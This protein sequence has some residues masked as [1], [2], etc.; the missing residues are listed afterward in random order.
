MKAPLPPLRVA[1]VGARRVRM[2]L[3]PFVAREMVRAGASLSSVVGTSTNSVAEACRD[4][5]AEFGGSVRGYTDI[6]AMLSHE[7][8]DVLA[9]LS[10]S[11]THGFYLRKALAA[12]LDVLCEKPL[13]WNEPNLCHS[14]ETLLADFQARERVLWENCPWPY[15]LP[16][17]FALFPAMRDAMPE[18]F[19]MRLAPT[20]TAAEML[21]ELLPHPLSLLQALAP[22]SPSETPRLEAIRFSHRDAH[23]S[24]LEVSFRYVAGSHTIAVRLGFERRRTPIPE[25]GFGINGKYA[26]R[27]VD[28]ESYRMSFCEGARSGVLPDPLAALMSDFLTAVRVRDLACEQMRKAQILARQRLWMQLLEDFRKA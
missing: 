22:C 23:R 18:S 4:L 20:N 13:L 3:G 21:G 12:N 28:P 24:D 11:E 26:A 16:A 9:I 2:G 15:T 25:V 1:L 17:Y 5:E 14:V 10:P 6:D 8:L 19:E 27:R 7:A